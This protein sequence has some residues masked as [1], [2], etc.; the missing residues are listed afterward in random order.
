MSNIL[1]VNKISTVET[2]TLIHDLWLDPIAAG[3][4]GFNAA[5]D[6]VSEVVVSVESLLHGMQKYR[7]SDPNWALLCNT[8]SISSWVQALIQRGFVLGFMVDFAVSWCYGRKP[9]KTSFQYRRSTPIS[10]SDDTLE[11]HTVFRY[12]IQIG[13]TAATTDS[14]G[15]PKGIFTKGSNNIWC[16]WIGKIIEGE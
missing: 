7:S 3:L 2:V 14:E 12:P 4:T 13:T 15:K 9:F 6:I 5:C 10:E 11:Y 8:L 1:A 16:S